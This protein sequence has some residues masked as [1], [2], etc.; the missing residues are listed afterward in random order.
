MCTSVHLHYSLFIHKQNTNCSLLAPFLGLGLFCSWSLI[1]CPYTTVFGSRNEAFVVPPF[2]RAKW[3]AMLMTT[4]FQTIWKRFPSEE[5]CFRWSG[6]V[7]KD[8]AWMEEISFLSSFQLHDLSPLWQLCSS[9][10]LLSKSGLVNMLNLF[11]LT[12]RLV[13]TDEST[14]SLWGSAAQTPPWSDRRG[15]TQEG[16]DGGKWADIWKGTVKS[17]Y[18]VGGPFK[19]T[20]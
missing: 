15:W 17:W 5:F 3:T 14:R 10:H 16:V 11:C 7:E 18:G 12:S 4:V 20:I 13:F 6:K 19:I 8:K 1:S 9:E 2:N